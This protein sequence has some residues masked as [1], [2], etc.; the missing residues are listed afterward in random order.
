MVAGEDAAVQKSSEP[1]ALAIDTASPSPTGLRCRSSRAPRANRLRARSRRGQRTSSMEILTQAEW[2]RFHLDGYLK[3]RRV[4]TDEQVERM[5]AALDRTIAE[6]LERDTDAG[7]P[8]EFRY[9]HDR[10]G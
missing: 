9:G 10:K 2:E 3:F 4:V 7:R 8:P 1:Q 5:R 6:E